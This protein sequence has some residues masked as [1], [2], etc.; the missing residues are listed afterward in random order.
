MEPRNLEGVCNTMRKFA[1][2]CGNGVSQIEHFGF[3]KLSV[4]IIWAA[5]PAAGEDNKYF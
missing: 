4:V 3:R 5:R 1:R 2:T